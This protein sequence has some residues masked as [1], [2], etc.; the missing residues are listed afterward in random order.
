M[1]L[2]IF[3]KLY[4]QQRL[5]LESFFWKENYQGVDVFQNDDIVI[6]AHQMKWHEQRNK[7][8]LAINKWAE[9]YFKDKINSDILT[10]LI[11]LSNSFTV[12]QNTK[13]DTVLKFNYNL[14]EYCNLSTVD[15]KKETVEYKFSNLMEWNTI[16]EYAD[17]L[18]Y[19]HRI[20]FSRR[21]IKRCF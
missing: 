17:K 1:W 7:T 11:L 9:E 6:W 8:Q 14:P 4:E 15:L 5:E 13:E 3:Y 10:D 19:K 12:N 20:G 16:D 21:I 18:Y 2:E